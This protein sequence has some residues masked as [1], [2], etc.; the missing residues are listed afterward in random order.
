M[1]RKSEIS[2]I[3]TSAGIKFIDNYSLKISKRSFIQKTKLSF[4][5]SYPILREIARPSI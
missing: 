2:A 5:L 4:T 3:E 1:K